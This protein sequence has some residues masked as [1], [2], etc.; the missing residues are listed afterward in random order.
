MCGSQNRRAAIRVLAADKRLGVYHSANLSISQSTG[1]QRI[2]VG[3]VDDRDVAR[4]KT[5]DQGFRAP[6]TA[7]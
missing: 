6:V 7:G 4:A 3:V 5:L 1:S 2:Q